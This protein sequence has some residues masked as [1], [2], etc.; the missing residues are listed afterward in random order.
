[1]PSH[2]TALITSGVCARAPV[3]STRLQT[4]EFIPPPNAKTIA[5]FK[6]GAKITLQV[7]LMSRRRPT[8]APPPVR[9][10]QL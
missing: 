9:L 8:A 1:M 5:K 10:L 4:E 7:T 6:L 3:D 2:Q